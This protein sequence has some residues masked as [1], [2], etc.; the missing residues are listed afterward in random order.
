M[1]P[2][3]Y[4]EKL[5]AEFSRRQMVNPRFSLRAF[6]N[7]IGLSAPFVSKVLSGKKNLSIDAAAEVAER[8]G[9]SSMEATQ[10]CRLVQL[11]GATS[12]RARKL[13]HGDVEVGD[14]F[15][16]VE[17]ET[18]QVIS[19]WYHYAILELSTCRG[20][21][22]E[23]DYIS[24]RLHISVYEAKGALSRL[25]RVGLL[26]NKYG[27]AKKSNKF[28][29]TPTD[30]SSRALR[31]FHLQMIEKARRSVEEQPVSVRDITGITLAIDSRKIDLAKKEIQKFRQRM[32]RLMDSKRADQVYQLNVQFF[33]LSDPLN[34]DYL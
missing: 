30:R 14:E 31:N 34:K 21:K 18:F 23:P 19:D 1:E 32:A 13:L 22:A 4:R 26:E 12:V 8:L 24:K 29:A 16:A 3:N 33:S 10:F 7:M 6:A 27:T 20:F 17:L 5:A 11:Q 25:L 15:N 2:E 28:I 9:Y